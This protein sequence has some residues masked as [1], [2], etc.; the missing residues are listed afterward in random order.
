MTLER[1]LTIPKSE[2][3]L[4]IGAEFER[5]RVLQEKDDADNFRLMLERAL[6]LI[7]LT[8]GDPK[9][10]NQLSMLLGLRTEVAKFYIGERRDKIAILY[11]AL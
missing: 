9:W 4:H 11:R 5:A 3:L 2:Q 10:L 7:D 6:E 1:W 8:I